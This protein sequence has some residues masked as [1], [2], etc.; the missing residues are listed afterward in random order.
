MQVNTVGFQQTLAELKMQIDRCLGMLISEYCHFD[1][2]PLQIQ[3]AM[4]DAVLSGGKRIRAA[5][6]LMTTS[7]L[8]GDVVS[9]MMPACAV[10]LIH[11]YSLVHDDLPAMDDD[12]MRRGRPS[13]H[14][15]YGEA[16]AILV[17]DALQALA[18]EAIANAERLQAD[19]RATLSA[20]QRLDCVR[21][22]AVAAG[23][24]GM[25][26]GQAY[27]IC[28]FSN[29]DIDRGVT[30]QSKP[31]MK[32][33]SGSNTDAD[34]IVKDRITTCHRGKTA[35]MF[36]AAT[37]VGAICTSAES[38]VI[39]QMADFGEH[40]GMAFQFADDRIDN[41]FPEH[42]SW[43]LSS[44][45]SYCDLATAA[46]REFDLAEY[47]IS[48]LPEM[49]RERGRNPRSAEVVGAGAG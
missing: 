32:S 35:A 23:A 34:D 49:I 46:I 42:D 26:G 3:L 30:V 14:I 4:N 29:K 31:M 5:I 17:G 7:A 12:D 45:E 37:A 20:K 21:E 39:K 27:D 40:I 11:A 6:S 13:C 19:G 47:P 1:G 48:V 28:H 36:R 24:R 25:V 22:L 41:D 38:H 15:A 43:L 9:A 2:D 8:G 18:F 33:T 16:A 44:C 10:E